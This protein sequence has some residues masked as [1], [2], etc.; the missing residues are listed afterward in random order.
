MSDVVDALIE[1]NSK[2]PVNY[3]W[4]REHH[5]MIAEWDYHNFLAKHG[6]EPISTYHVDFNEGDKNT[7]AFEKG[8]E[9]V[10]RKI[11]GT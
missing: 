4:T 11:T 5:E 1:F 2:M 6:F 3:V 7:S 8:L 10:L 9:Y